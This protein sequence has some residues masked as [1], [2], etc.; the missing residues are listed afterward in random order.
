MNEL[1]DKELVNKV[2]PAQL[3]RIRLD[4]IDILHGKPHLLNSN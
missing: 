1:I 3:D 4:M 2:I